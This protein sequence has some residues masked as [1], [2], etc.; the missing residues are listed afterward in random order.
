MAIQGSLDYRQKAIGR[1]PGE[2]WASCGSRAAAYWA[3]CWRWLA[4]AGEAVG[5]QRGRLL[6]TKG[7]AS[8]ACRLMLRPAAASPEDAWPAGW[9]VRVD[10]RDAGKRRDGPR[11]CGERARSRREGGPQRARKTDNAVMLRAATRRGAKRSARRTQHNHALSVFRAHPNGGTHSG[12][13]LAAS[14]HA[15]GRTDVCSVASIHAD[16]P[17]GGPSVRWAS[18]WIVVAGNS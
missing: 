4:D 18:D 14:R 7:R 15:A 3:T 17:T 2:V 6:A 9:L 10:A 16:K 11:R 1:Q 12:L 8:A 13:L 5:G